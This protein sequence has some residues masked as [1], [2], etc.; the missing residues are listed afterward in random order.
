MANANTQVK[1]S[2][3]FKGIVKAIGTQRLIATAALIVIYLFFFIFGQSGF[4][5]FSTLVSIFDSAYYIGFMA[6][7]VT[8]VIATGGIDLSIGTVLICSALIGGTMY[9]AGVPIVV[10]LICMLIIGII[11]GTIN[12]LLV[13]KLGMPPFIATLGMMMFTRGFGSIMSKATT[14][15]FP[16]S[17]ADASYKNLFRT[18]NN[19]PTGVILLLACAIIMAVV[20]NKTRVGRYILAI[21]SNKEATR[22]SGVN[23]AKYETYAYIISGFFAALGGISYAAINTTIMPATGNGFEMDAITGV[24]IGG[25][26][27]S[28]GIA[29]IAGTIIGVLI[30]AVLKTG[31]PFIGLQPHYQMVVTGI[32]LVIAVFADVTT[33]KRRN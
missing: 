9:K 6:I 24:V 23:V 25:T 4:K 32:V 27:M 20:L 28:G 8:F 16:I 15:T 7:G 26:S 22:L 1:S 13:A 17:G 11:C 5:Q 31:L 14:V 30:M 33:R 10:C 18:G 3:G 29:S 21:G 12:G 19:I 2:G